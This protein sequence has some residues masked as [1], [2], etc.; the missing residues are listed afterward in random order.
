MTLPNTCQPECVDAVVLL[1]HDLIKIT[2]LD[3]IWFDNGRPV[4]ISL[5]IPLL[6]P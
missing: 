5:G 4:S 3:S 6:H 2:L 1:H